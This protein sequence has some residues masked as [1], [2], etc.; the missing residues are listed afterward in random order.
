MADEHDTGDKTELPTDRRREEVRERGN[1]AR[2]VDLSVAASVLVA[3]AIL[4]F[5]G[6]DMAHS[7]LEILRRSLS[8]PA[9]IELDVPRLMSELLALA[10]PVAA[11]LLPGLA[12]VMVS[13]VAV[14]AAQ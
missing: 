11:V 8:A 4:N 5:F 2:S 14:N 9:W 13:A 6:G 10:K 3:A 7:L 12:L 1:V